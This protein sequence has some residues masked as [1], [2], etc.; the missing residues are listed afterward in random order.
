MNIFFSLT[1]EDSYPKKCK[2]HARPCWFAHAHKC[3]WT[4]Q[5]HSANE[6]ESRESMT[7][8]VDE[9][10]N[11]RDAN[12][13]ADEVRLAC[14]TISDAMDRS[15]ASRVLV[16]YRWDWSSVVNRLIRSCHP[17]DRCS[18]RLEGDEENQIDVLRRFGDER[19][20]VTV[21]LKMFA[22]DWCWFDLHM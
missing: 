8:D 21:R 11:E 20:P 2:R 13:A 17:W 15:C 6:G 4:D 19:L 5:I 18:S 14:D 22:K 12:V 9:N 7:L 3:I 16:P 1:Q 10:A